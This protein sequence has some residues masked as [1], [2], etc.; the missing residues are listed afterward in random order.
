MSWLNAALYEFG[1]KAPEEACLRAWRA[2]LL[3]ELDGDVLEVGAGTGFNMP[4][5][6]DTIQRVVVT[7]PD[8]H[9]RNKLR[10]VLDPIHWPRF[11]VVAAS[12][13]GL[14]MPDASFDA[15]I[16]TLVL[17]SVNDL[18]EALAEIRRVLK[19]GGRF[20]FLEHVA[21]EDGSRLHTWQRRI[22]SAWKHVSGNCHLTRHTEEAIAE[23]GFAIERIEREPIR[24]AMPL[25]R[26]SIRGVARK[27]LSER[28]SVASHPLP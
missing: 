24:E 19:P 2:E 22:E 25:A 23:T 28:F 5:Y 18:H 16:S 21:A 11:E 17:C 26:P 13:D 10:R 9:M 14:P 6:P 3:N 4:F 27:P 12:L 20:V 7:E 8:P 1:M 15:V